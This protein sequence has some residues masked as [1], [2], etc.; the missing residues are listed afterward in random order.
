MKKKV[1]KPEDFKGLRIGTATA[2]RALTEGW[3]AAPV[4][5]QLTDYY[6]A[7]ERNTVDGVSSSTLTNWVELRA[8]RRSRSIWFSPGYLQSLGLRHDESEHLEKA[9]ARS[10]AGDHGRHDLLGEDLRARRATEDKQKAMQKMKDAK[11]EVYTARA[12]Y[13][14]VARG[15]R[16]QL[17][18]GVSAEDV[19]P[20]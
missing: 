3:G 15:H 18:L 6:T 7:M 5:L 2:A 16:L 13:G 1:E 11:V 4:N 12:E 17:D 10:P 20:T 14:E 9:P 19:F 8:V